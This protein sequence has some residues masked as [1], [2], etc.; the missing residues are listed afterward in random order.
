MK[1]QTSCYLGNFMPALLG[2]LRLRTNLKGFKR[3][4]LSTNLAQTPVMR[5]GWWWKYMYIQVSS[6]SKAS[7]LLGNSFL[8]RILVGEGDGGSEDA[9]Q[10]TG[11]PGIWLRLQFWVAKRDDFFFKKVMKAYAKKTVH[12]AP[13]LCCS[14]PCN[15]RA[16]VTFARSSGL[17]PG[18]HKPP[19]IATGIMLHK[20]RL[21]QVD[22]SRDYESQGEERE[23]QH[24]LEAFSVEL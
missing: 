8:R 5:W 13:T 23:A 7:T 19:P 24:F 17:W 15:S 3:Y 6:I 20:K 18:P 9:S 4:R 21:P 2:S 1:W 14:G 12:I 10:V 16:F 11:C 22:Y